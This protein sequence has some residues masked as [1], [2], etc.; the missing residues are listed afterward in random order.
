MYDIREL[1]ENNYAD[2]VKLFTKE[3]SSKNC[4]CTWWMIPVKTYHENG[5]AGNKLEFEKQMK[6]NDYPMGLLAY[7]KDEVV[8]WCAV[9]PRDRYT[10]A[11]KTPTYQ[12]RN[13]SEDHDVW[14]VSCFYIDK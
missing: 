2:Y 4:F 6:E 9:G 12:G 10:R 14:L 8:G 3:E 7:D 5:H 1:K 13:S 11:V